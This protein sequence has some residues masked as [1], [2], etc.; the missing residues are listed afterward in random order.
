MEGYFIGAPGV[1]SM[2]IPS[3][4]RGSKLS[5]GRINGR[6]P[7]PVIFNDEIDTDLFGIALITIQNPNMSFSTSGIL[8]SN[9]QSYEVPAF[10]VPQSTTICR[11]TLVWESG[12]IRCISSSLSETATLIATMGFQ[13]FY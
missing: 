6:A 12:V 9:R 4:N 7:L 2:L 5:V 8:V 11:L 10:M 3:V 13:F 1:S